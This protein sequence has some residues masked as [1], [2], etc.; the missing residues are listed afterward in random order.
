[1]SEM[2]E[3]Q[4]VAGAIQDVKDRGYGSGYLLAGDSGR[5]CILGSI[6][7]ARW[8]EQWDVDCRETCDSTDTDT[9]MYVRLAQDPLTRSLIGRIGD[10]IKAKTH[11]EMMDKSGD[12]FPDEYVICYVYGW[13]DDLKFADGKENVLEVLEKVQAS[14]GIEEM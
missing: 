13:N 1:M 8:G 7:Y 4:L 12:T 6:G 3:A 10:A 11:T 2:S 9:K 5:H 14:I